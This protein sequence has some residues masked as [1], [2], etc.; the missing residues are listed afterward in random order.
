[1]GLSAARQR[2]PKG[3][4]I[5]CLD[6]LLL[7]RDDVA[8]ARVTYMMGSLRE[9][10]EQYAKV[11]RQLLILHALPQ[12]AIPALA[13]ALK[14]KA[15]FLNQDVEPYSH[16][17]DR[18]VT[19]ALQL[20]GI[21]VQTF[22]DQLLHAP[23]EVMAGGGQPYTV[24]TP[25]WRNWRVQP[26]AQPVTALNAAEGLTSVEQAQAAQAGAIALPTAQ[27]LDFFWP[28]EL[29]LKPGS[30]AA[31]ERLDEFCDRVIFE[32]AERRNFPGIQGTSQLSA[33]LKFGTIGIRTVWAATETALQH[34]RSD[35]AQHSIVSWQ[36]E[37][38]WR[39][40]YQHA[41]YYHAH[42]ITSGV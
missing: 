42:S 29:P 5:F 31:Q 25:F 30:Q 34:T 32:Y 19:E 39:E 9:L 17:R 33:A 41:L 22:W 20:A 23:R 24:F 18:S 11:G 10:R 7:E 27:D 26:K 16:D 13:I 6:P 28:N 4:G 21:E 3:V 12:Q 37:L 15:V 38:A 1:V 2:S 35:E 40:F 8:P 36:Q 14:A